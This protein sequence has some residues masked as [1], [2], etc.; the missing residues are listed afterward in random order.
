MVHAARGAGQKILSE[1]D[2]VKYYSTGTATAGSPLTP[3]LSAKKGPLDTTLRLAFS[4]TGAL[5]VWQAGFNLFEKMGSAVIPETVKAGLVDKYGLDAA[6]IDRRTQAAT[7]P[8]ESRQARV[9][10]PAAIARRSGDSARPQS[11][12]TAAPLPP[13]ARTGG[14]GRSR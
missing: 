10:C 7:A 13:S 8:R 6:V 11:R 14:S 3:S 5:K 1:R 9:V 2:A 12:G 4:Q